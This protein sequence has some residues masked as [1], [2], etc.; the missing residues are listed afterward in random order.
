[1]TADS[2][3]ET[4]SIPGHLAPTPERLERLLS[5]Q[6]LEELYEVEEQPFA[7]AA[8]SKVKN[9]V[10]LYKRKIQFTKDSCA[11]KRSMLNGSKRFRS[12]SRASGH[13]YRGPARALFVKESAPTARS[14]SICTSDHLSEYLMVPLDFVEVGE[15]RD[16]SPRVIVFSDERKPESGI[17]PHAARLKDISVHARVSTRTI[18]IEN[19][20]IN[21]GTVHNLNSFYPNRGNA[22]L[23][24]NGPA[25]FRHTIR[26][27][28]AS[29]GSAT[30]DNA[31]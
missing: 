22:N 30:P 9:E 14:R 16:L 10:S 6:T 5:K 15:S 8:R 19:P 27:V 12:S 11:Q 2:L 23:R 18:P 31:N 25:N 13:L 20:V 28:R 17:I 29:V 24:F 7:R 4:T 1:M 21:H 26:Y 3:F